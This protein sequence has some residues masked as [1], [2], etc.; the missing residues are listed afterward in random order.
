MFRVTRFDEKALNTITADAMLD[1]F[2]SR[3]SRR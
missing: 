1:G 3:K 2:A